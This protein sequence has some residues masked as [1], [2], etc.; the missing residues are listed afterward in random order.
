VKYTYNKN[1]IPPEGE[2]GRGNLY[3]K[4]QG[5]VDYGRLRANKKINASQ[6]D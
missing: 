1:L 2:T 4:Q 5:N 6:N 3:G